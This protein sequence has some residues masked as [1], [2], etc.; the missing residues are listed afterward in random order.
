M[1]GLRD[2][3]LAAAAEGIASH[4]HLRWL[5]YAD[6]ELHRL[7]ERLDLPTPTGYSQGRPNYACEASAPA[8]ALVEE[9]ESR[10]GGRFS[11]NDFRAVASVIEDILAQAIGPRQ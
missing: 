11:S 3:M 5:T 4:D 2:P 1:S 10:M 8:R 9:V 6:D 7:R